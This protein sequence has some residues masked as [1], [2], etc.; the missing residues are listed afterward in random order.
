M[1]KPLIVISKI[2]FMGYNI[3]VEQ[4]GSLDLKQFD[5]HFS[6]SRSGDR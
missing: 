6:D 4:S 2:L 3:F 5:R 1:R